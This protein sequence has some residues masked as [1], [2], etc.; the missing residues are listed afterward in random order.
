MNLS[1]LNLTQQQIQEMKKV[2]V[3]EFTASDGKTYQICNTQKLTKASNNYFS[4][5][6]KLL[7]G[8]ESNYVVPTQAERDKLIEHLKET[9]ENVTTLGEIQSNLLGFSRGQRETQC[10]L[11]TIRTNTKNTQ[12]KIVDTIVQ[13]YA[14]NGDAHMT[15]QAVEAN[16]APRRNKIV[17]D[18][19]IYDGPSLEKNLTQSST[20]IA[21]LTLDKNRTTPS[22]SIFSNKNPLG[23][24]Y[25]NV[26]ESQLAKVHAESKELTAL[27]LDENTAALAAMAIALPVPTSSTTQ[28]L[29]PAAARVGQLQP[30]T[31]TS[32]GPSAAGE[33]SPA[34]SAPTNIK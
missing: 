34:P 9:F 31:L 21:D 10:A 6:N 28:L 18:S 13:F 17:K 3:Y 15:H 2:G 25:K 8:L 1:S 14:L 5:V 22:K 4:Q 7:T 32:V 30:A 27:I 19:I 12:K 33:I 20:M 29:T 23:S 24:H 26:T 16:M 11:D